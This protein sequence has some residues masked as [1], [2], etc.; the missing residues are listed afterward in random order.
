MV[1]KKPSTFRT[2]SKTVSMSEV[3]A[4]AA[5]ELRLLHEGLGD[6]DLLLIPPG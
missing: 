2:K 4:I 6:D 5:D 3:R 1:S